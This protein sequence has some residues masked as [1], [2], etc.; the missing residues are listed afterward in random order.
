MRA[1]DTWTGT[2]TGLPEF[3]DEGEELQLPAA[4]VVDHDLTVTYAHYG[5]V[6]SDTPTADELAALLK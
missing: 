6:I 2:F 3:D 1:G 4:F 5:R